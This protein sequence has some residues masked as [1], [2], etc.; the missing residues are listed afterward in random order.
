MPAKKKVEK[1]KKEKAAPKVELFTVVQLGNS[2]AEPRIWAFDGKLNKVRNKPD[3]IISGS[4]RGKNEVPAGSATAPKG[5]Y[6]IV[7]PIRPTAR[8]PK[9][10]KM[11]GWFY[12]VEGKKQW[13]ISAAPLGGKKPTAEPAKKAPAKAAPAKKAR[14]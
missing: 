1:K 13:I 11:D 8:K 5:T 4:L 14:K 2:H 12:K 10:M 9:A 6:M 3:R 7:G